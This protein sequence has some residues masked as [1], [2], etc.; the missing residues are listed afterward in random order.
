MV[1]AGSRTLRFLTAL[2]WHGEHLRAAERI[3][4]WRLVRW[5]GRL[6]ITLRDVI[7]RWKHISSVAWMEMREHIVSDGG[8]G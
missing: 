4:L 1:L 2:L 3:L 5:T 8:D 7:P 6:G